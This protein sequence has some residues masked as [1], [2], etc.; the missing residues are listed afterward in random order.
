MDWL[1]FWFVGE[2]FGWED[3]MKDRTEETDMGELKDK[4]GR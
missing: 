2:T 1:C 3:K 4:M